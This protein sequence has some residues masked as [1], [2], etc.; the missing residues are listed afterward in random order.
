MVHSDIW[1]PS[2]LPTLGGARYYVVFVDDYSRYTWIYLFH[3]RSAL[4]KI[5]QEFSTMIQTQFS[6]TIKRFRADSGGEFQS[7]PFTELLAS[8]GTLAESSCTDTPQQN[9]VAER[10]H[11]HIMEITRALLLS[12]STP[13]KFWG[14]AALTSVYVINRTPSSVIGGISPFERLYKIPPNYSELRVFGSTCFVLL[15]KVE[16]DKLS[17]RATICVLLGYGIG[18]KGYRCYDPIAQKLRV[19]RNVTFWE[20]IPLYML[21]RFRDSS[22]SSESFAFL[23]PFLDSSVKSLD[24][25]VSSPECP[26]IVS[27]YHEPSQPTEEAFPIKDDVPCPNIE[28]SSNDPSPLIQELRRSTREHIPSQRYHDF[29][30]F[31]STILSVYEPRSYH[32][33]SSNPHWQAAMKEELAALEQ[34]HT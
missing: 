5:Y 26:P 33:A 24:P 18:K 10:K 9:G 11:R 30:C 20:H 29:H 16:R 1:G 13:K 2:R 14:E 25:M 22:N 12:S 23:D 6:T 4:L 31:L 19:L 8:R 21:P 28:A 15:P 3:N 7:G 17:K 27:E 32:E 34:T